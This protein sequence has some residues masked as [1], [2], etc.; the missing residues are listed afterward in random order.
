MTTSRGAL[1][2]GPL[3]KI[4]FLRLSLRVG[5]THPYTL[6][7]N[8][9][10]YIYFLTYKEKKIILSFPYQVSSHTILIFN[11]IKFHPGEIQYVQKVVT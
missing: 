7:K 1:L 5:D 9:N 2:L 11:I 4:F 10:M 8:N 3:E 6:K